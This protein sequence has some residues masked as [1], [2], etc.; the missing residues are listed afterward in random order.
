[1]KTVLYSLKEKREY[2]EANV[3]LIDI[4]GVTILATPSKEPLVLK[5][6]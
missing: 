3:T 2:T 5:V 1:M 6:R 4:N